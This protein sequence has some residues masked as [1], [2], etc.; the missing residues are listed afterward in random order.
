MSN[1]T[2]PRSHTA[3]PLRYWV[4]GATGGLGHNV[5]ERLC[6][7]D[8]TVFAIGRNAAIGETLTQLGA[9]FIPVELTQTSA[10]FWK[11]QFHANDIVIHCAA[12]S[13]PWGAYRD[14]YAINV[15][16]TEQ[17]A[18]AALVQGVARFVHISTP[19]LYFNFTH[20]T[21]I[22]ESAPLPQPVNHYAATKRLAEERL[23]TYA[24]QGL[25]I[26]IL[27]P[28]AIYGAHDNVLVPRILR[29]YRN[30]VMP[31]IAG[32]Q[33]WVDLTYMD[34]LV[35]AIV[36][37]AHEPL[38]F[39]TKKIPT[40]NISNGDPIQLKTVFDSLL[41]HIGPAP[42]YKNIPWHVIHPLS[43]ILQAMAKITRREPILTPYSAG[44]LAFDQTLCIEKAQI[45]LNYH[46]RVRTLEGIERYLKWRTHHG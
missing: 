43:H 1:Q 29:A 9:Q 46:P 2:I 16:A 20:Q 27:R 8:A 14:F 10:Q 13:S 7:H 34:N 45:E 15:H 5:V 28:R 25:N 35:D 6:A 30:G 11:S 22:R 21:N 37:G 42:R 44:V 4:T 41:T 19:S 32:G 12:L 33:A 24:Q 31:L 26:C 36:L 39:S 17:L 23:R 18:Q 3:S 40:Y 38:D